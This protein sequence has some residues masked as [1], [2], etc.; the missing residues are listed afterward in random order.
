MKRLHQLH[1]RLKIDTPLLREYDAII[2]DQEK[3]GIIEH[4]VDNNDAEPRH[5]LLHHAVIRKDK[6]TTKVS[7]VF[8]GSAKSSK[9]DLSVNDCLERGPNLVPHL[10]DT[11]VK[12]RGYPVG[13]IADIEKAFHQI[14]ISPNDRKMLRFL[15]FD[16]IY[17]DY[18][19]IKVYQFCQLPFGLTPSPAVLPTIILHHLSK[20]KEK[21]P[22]V[23]SLLSESLYVDDLAGG[24]NEDDEA[25]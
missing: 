10:F 15:W 21:E 20:F 11:I 9:D 16:N 2:K 25:V 17:D 5:F 13:L 22:E 14:V 23:V 19:V 3:T 4:V 18:P 24:A 6:Q 12:F 1:S 8:D 7:V